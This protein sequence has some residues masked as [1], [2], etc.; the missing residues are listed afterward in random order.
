MEGAEK[1]G[2]NWIRKWR[3]ISVSLVFTTKE[4]E[5]LL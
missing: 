1:Y 3:L 5:A 4:Q 2:M